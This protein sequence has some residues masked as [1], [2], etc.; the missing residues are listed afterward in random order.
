MVGVGELD[1]GCG[2]DTAC[3]GEPAFFR[4]EAFD[5]LEVPEGFGAAIAVLRSE[6]VAR[7]SESRVETKR[8]VVPLG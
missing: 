1:L 3:E 5:G 8:V 6:L 7:S 4:K 2:S